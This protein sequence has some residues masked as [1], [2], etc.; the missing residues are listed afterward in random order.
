MTVSRLLGI[1]HLPLPGLRFAVLLRRH[2]KAVTQK[3]RDGYGNP[4][5]IFDLGAGGRTAIGRPAG[6]LMAPTG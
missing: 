5:R 1:G 3:N 6:R 4:P 2:G